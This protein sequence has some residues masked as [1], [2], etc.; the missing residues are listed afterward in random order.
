[1]RTALRAAALLAL[2]TAVPAGVAAADSFTPVRLTIDVAPIARLHKPLAVTVHVGADAGA[3][4]TRTAPLRIRVKLASEC[5]GTFQYTSGV[6]LLDKRLSPQP[7]T[8][9]AYSA[10]ARGSGRPSSYGPKV[11]CTYLEEE[12]DNRMFANDESVQSTVSKA[13]TT[14]AVRY[15]ALRRS[16][17]ART[18]RS[19][20]LAARRAARR[21]CG[22]GVPL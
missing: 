6:V 8:G 22:P 15:D 5:G 21:A 3:L 1:L 16:R 7:A 13:C 17:R 11:V 10:L 12:G 18:H 14:A 9:Q 19:R 2:A 20:V 4:D